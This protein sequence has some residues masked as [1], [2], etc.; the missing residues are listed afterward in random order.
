[1][2]RILSQHGCLLETATA[3]GRETE[4]KK[5]MQEVRGFSML[6]ICAGKTVS[7]YGMHN[8]G[9]QLQ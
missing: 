1:M 4:F 9:G 3:W 2:Q 5:F 7:M 8:A 6:D